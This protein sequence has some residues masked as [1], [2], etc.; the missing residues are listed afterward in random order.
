MLTEGCIWQ[1]CI[2]H[3]SSFGLLAGELEVIK[4]HSRAEI[5]KDTFRSILSC[6]LENWQV[7]AVGH[8]IGAAGVAVF[9]LASYCS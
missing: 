3:L 1:V 2:V 9:E 5:P 6:I 8:G 4:N 7:S